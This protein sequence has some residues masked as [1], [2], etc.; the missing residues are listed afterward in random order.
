V[1]RIVG[2]TVDI[3]AYEVADAIENATPHAGG[4]NQDGVLD[5]LQ[6]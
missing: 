1:P 6:S 5:S 2:G 3:G 4:G